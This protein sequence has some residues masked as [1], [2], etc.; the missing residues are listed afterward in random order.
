[1][2]QI[3]MFVCT[4]FLF[5]FSSQIKAKNNLPDGPQNLYFIENNG[6]VRDQHS[7]P[8]ND[9]Q[10]V[11]RANGMT[12]FIGDAQM[13][14]QFSR[15]TSAC[16]GTFDPICDLSAINYNAFKN[17]ACTNNS[18]I[19]TY[20]MDVEL[21]GA[22]K[23]PEIIAE[24]RQEYYE[25][26]YLP[27]CPANGIQAHSYKK[28]IYKNVYPGIDWVICIKNNKLEHEFIVGRNGDASKIRLKYN[29]QTSLKIN[30]DGSITATT[31]LGA[32]REYAPTCYSADGNIVPSSFRLH[33]NV[34]SYNLNISRGLVIDPVLEWGTYYGPDST[35]SQFYNIACDNFPH[36]YACGLT[37]SGLSGTIA[38][39][40][41]FQDT[42]GGT[43]DGFLVKFDSSG[44]RIWGT[45]YG[46]NNASWSTAVATDN[47]G[48][49][50]MGGST[51]S[52]IGIATAGSQIPNYIGNSLWVGFCV[53]FNAA[54]MRLWGTYVGGCFGPTFDL[55]IASIVCDNL[56]HVYVSGSTDDTANV[57]TPGSFK[58]RK[59]Y[60]ADTVDDFVIQYD[61]TGVELWGTYYGGPHNEYGGSLC[62]DGSYIYLS[63]F[64][65]SDT[66][67]GRAPAGT[68][69][70]TSGSYQ[71]YF[72][73][74]NSDAFLVKFNST[75]NRMWGT[76]YGGSSDETTGG[77][78]CDKYGDIY[79][80][81]ATSSDT[82]I[83]SPGC[84]Q[85]V[86]AGAADAFLAKFSPETG[87]RIWGT[88]YG[89][90]GVEDV[91]YST[92]IMTDSL[93]N[94][95]IV[96]YTSSTTGIASAGTWQSTYGGGDRDAFFAKY[97]GAGIQKWSTYYGGGGSDDGVSCAYDGMG[98]YICG[99]TNSTDNIATPGSF[100]SSGG[101]ATFYYQGFIAKFIDPGT[102]L[103][104]KQ[105]VSAKCF[106]IYPNPNNGVFTLSGRVG[107]S[108]S[109]VVQITITDIAGRVIMNDEAEIN[110]GKIQKQMVLNSKIPCGEYFVR[111]VSQDRVQVLKLLID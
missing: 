44:H 111:V 36:I 16:E 65:Y 3:T 68:G 19:E 96:G 99:E 103:N 72:G 23:H 7:S 49:I 37:Y 61:T 63:G 13:H 104:Q 110:D 69:V 12:I 80:L 86:R 11:M 39:T 51:N 43:T 105:E 66:G 57:T 5:A 22:N 89:G 70:S 10:Y 58:P 98:A 8:R 109:G 46:G 25:N 60:G 108:E 14:Y 62:T 77:A 34:L 84:F 52:T 91:Q 107:S 102:L 9:V 21:V 26:Y 45:Y 78:I 101:G 85:P 47:V 55:E 100:L 27:G 50:Y 59:Y 20:R 42:L 56:N 106:L 67:T 4:V 88:Y 83:A 64:T 71:P 30:E 90:P 75:G 54:G 33:N 95:Y 18:V 94:V 53:K 32:V 17:P 79:L 97:N 81:G 76:Y 6:Q 40:G 1:M 93:D 87:M 35:T 41:S 73:G 31:S 38:T 2:K 15:G 24:E 48:N 82:G 74:G 28:V 92:T 29:G